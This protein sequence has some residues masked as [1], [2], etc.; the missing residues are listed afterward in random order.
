MNSKVSHG[1][2]GLFEND[3]DF[4]YYS[5]HDKCWRYWF[6]STWKYFAD[7]DW[8]DFNEIFGLGL[9]LKIFRSCI[10]SEN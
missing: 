1:G 2:L 9:N 6:D 3:T 8:F 7:S 5:E 4:G 10:N